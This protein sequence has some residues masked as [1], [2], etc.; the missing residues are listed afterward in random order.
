LTI[1]Q[2]RFTIGASLTIHD[3]QFTIHNYDR[4]SNRRMALPGNA[5]L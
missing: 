1:D 2:L 4:F 3:S 5:Q